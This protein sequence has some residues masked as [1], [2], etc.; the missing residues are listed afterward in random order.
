MLR[1]RTALDRS[2]Y[3]RVN[4]GIIAK[5][6]NIDNTT[7]PIQTGTGKKNRGSYMSAHVNLFKK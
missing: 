5:D 7:Q 6:V 1:T 3:E 4:F 2:K